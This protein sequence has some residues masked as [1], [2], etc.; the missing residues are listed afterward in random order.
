M[1]AS[2]SQAS[3][4]D[5]MAK[6]KTLRVVLLLLLAGA[7]AWGYYCF[8]ERK[9][10]PERALTLYG[11]VDIRQ[12]QLAFYDTGR[13]VRL[14][15]EEGDRVKE[16]QLV[17]EMD[18]V[19]YASDVR[20]L[21]GK[22]EA[23]QQ[24]VTR[25]HNGT[26]PQEIEQARATVQAN[27]ATLKDAELTYERTKGLV[28]TDFAPQQQLDDA[29]AKLKTARAHLKEAKEALELAVIGP[30]QEDIAEAEAQLRAYQASLELA[31][32]RLQDTRLY[33][34]APGII[35][36]RILEPGDMAFPESPV[37]TLALTRPMW[38]RAYVPEPSL[39]KIVPGM[40]ADISTDSYPGKVYQ[41]WV[42]F[43]SPTAEFTPKNVETPDL[44]TRLVYEVRAYICDPR[45]ELRLGMPATVR[46]PL[47]Q[48]RSG[49]GG[50]HDGPC[51]EG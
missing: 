48:P 26:R 20:Q 33:A 39:G 49:V 41:G 15:V 34:P 50:S 47:D 14:L 44:R 40:R 7:L 37:F 13:I 38:V 10:A 19:R 11:N 36:D 9:C 25:L 1:A 21:E 45:D 51:R 46:I 23:Q 12:V 17:A 24:V 16:G 42:G 5:G 29:T 3:Y 43:I 32:Q 22:L 27:E 4:G 6:R 30:R 35:R 2:R 18:P 28:A 8:R 31:R